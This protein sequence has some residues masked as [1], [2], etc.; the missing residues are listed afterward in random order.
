MVLFI[1][2]RPGNIVGKRLEISTQFKS[3]QSDCF[4]QYWYIEHI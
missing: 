1:E 2:I 3:K 4:N